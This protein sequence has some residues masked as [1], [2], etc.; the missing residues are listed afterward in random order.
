[1]KRISGPWMGLS[2]AVA[3]AAMLS[4]G[5]DAAAQDKKAPAAKPAASACKGLDE[6][7]CKSKAAE[8]AWIV[9]KKGKQKPY[10]RS[11]SKRS[12]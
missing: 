4:F 9:P 7:A 8:C 3:I 10:C 6:K 12:K 5:L 1:M 11:K 2:A